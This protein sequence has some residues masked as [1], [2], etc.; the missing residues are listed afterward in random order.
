MLRILNI[1][2]IH[3]YATFSFESVQ[4]FVLQRKKLVLVLFDRVYNQGVYD[5]VDKL[6]L[7]SFVMSLGILCVGVEA[8]IYRS[9][10][11]FVVIALLTNN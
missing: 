1:A 4:T 8:L 10:R 5:Q 7:F 6:G 9:W 2:L 3:S 11:F